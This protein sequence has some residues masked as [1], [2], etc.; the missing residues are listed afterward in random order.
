MVVTVGKARRGGEKV[1]VNDK[2]DGWGWDGWGWM[3][4]DGEW[5]GMRIYLMVRHHDQSVR[6][7]IP[8]P[9]SLAWLPFNDY[10]ISDTL[11]TAGEDACFRPSLFD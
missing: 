10:L 4:M 3:G 6:K 11:V 2:E 8:N 5:D 9:L 1:E 7:A